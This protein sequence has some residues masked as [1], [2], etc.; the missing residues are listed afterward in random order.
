MRV[1]RY[2]KVNL[3]RRQVARSPY[4]GVW[5]CVSRTL[6]AEGIGAFYRSYRTTARPY[7]FVCDMPAH[8]GARAMC[9]LC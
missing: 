1:P 4:K 3:T 8:A 6:R 5:D 7:G 2:A 9:C